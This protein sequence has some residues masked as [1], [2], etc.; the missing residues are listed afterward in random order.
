MSKLN[1]LFGEMSSVSNLSNNMRQFAIRA[2]HATFFS[3][4]TPFNKKTAEHNEQSNT[5]FISYY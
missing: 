5:Y 4:R 1:K 2:T 3:E